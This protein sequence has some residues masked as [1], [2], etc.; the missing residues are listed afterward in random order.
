MPAVATLSLQGAVG[1]SANLVE[2]K[3]S[4]GTVLVNVNLSGVLT[5]PSFVPSSST[6]PTNGVYLPAADTLGLA[7]ASTVRL[8]INAA[9]EV[10]I[11]SAAS[12]AQSLRVS[13]S[14]TGATTA[15]GIVS[16]GTV[17]SDVVSNYSSYRST[18]NTQAASF[19]L[20]NFFNYGAVGGTI[21]AGSTITNLF[22]FHVESSVNTGTNN[23]AFY[24]NIAASGTSNW[25]FYNANTA[26]VTLGT[27]VSGTT[28]LTMGAANTVAQQLGVV[29]IAST[30]VGVVIRGAASQSANLTEWQ[31]S[32]PATL[33]AI[34]STG[35]INFASGN[36]ASTA[37]IGA[38]TA[39]VMVAG[40]ITM[41]VAG[42]TVKVPYYNN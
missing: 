39:P 36:T 38:I 33:T 37:T 10:G 6:V 20:V 27:A 30:R 9:G 25:A 11:G 40:Y 29:A 1:Q 3:N 26:P 19:T 8:Q 5:A 24:S 4:T 28:N 42:T 2:V 14:P 16:N 35:T 31:S 18:V 41:Q 34:T 7:T 15:F 22:G 13:K 17:L 23:Y 21:G 32:T 12:T